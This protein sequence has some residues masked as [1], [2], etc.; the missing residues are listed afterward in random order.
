VQEREAQYDS[1]RPNAQQKYQ[2]DRAIEAEKNFTPC[3]FCH[4][5]RNRFPWPPG[6]AIKKP[7]KPKPSRYPAWKDDDFESIPEDDEDEANAADNRKNLHS[8]QFSII[9]SITRLWYN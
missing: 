2:R 8:V 9:Q 5:S 6:A 3:P 7:G 4:A 1:R